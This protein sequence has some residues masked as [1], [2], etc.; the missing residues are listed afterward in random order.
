MTGNMIDML[1]VNKLSYLEI[2]DEIEKFYLK[3]KPIAILAEE[4]S[5]GDP[6]IEVMQVQKKLPVRP[7]VTTNSSKAR[8]IQNLALKF[9]K[10]RIFAMRDP[11]LIR[12]LQAFTIDVTPSGKTK[13]GGTRGYNDDMVVAFAIANEA[14][15]ELTHVFSSRIPKLT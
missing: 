2:I 7:F 4:N 1:V 15:N 10:K 13:Y 8:I 6:V 5:A 11:E 3:W 9:E 14:I 12:Q